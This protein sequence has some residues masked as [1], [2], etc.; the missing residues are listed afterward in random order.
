MNRLPC[1]ALLCVFVFG[2][3]AHAAEKV[4]NQQFKSAGAIRHVTLYRDRAM[5]T[6]EIVVPPGDALR[7]IGVSDLPARAFPESLSAEGDE[8]TVVRAVRVSEHQAAKPRSDA[9][10][11]AAQE[12]QHLNQQLEDARKLLDVANQNLAS[13]DELVSFSVVAGKNDLNHG[14]LNAETLTTLAD[15][16][17]TKRHELL[18]EQL[19]CQQRLNDLK[20]ELRITQRQRRALR[21]GADQGTC[22]ARIFVETEKGAAARVQLSYL[23]ADCGWSPQYTVHGRAGEPTFDVRYSA[24]IEQRSGEPWQG[25]RL[26]LSTAS[27]S[28]SAARPVLTPLRITSID[29]NKAAGDLKHAG[30]GSDPFDAA[31]DLPRRDDLSGMLQSLRARQQQAENQI[32]IMD[33]DASPK[34]RDILLNSLAGKM[35]EIELQAE[36]K[37]WRTL[38]PDANGDIASQVYTLARPVTLDSR[39]ETQLVQIVDMQLPGKMYYV[40]T[41]LLSTYAYREVS[42][43][44]SQPI[45][46]LRGPT[47]VYLNDRFVGHTQ[48]PST[49]SGQQLAIG[50]GADQQVR[51]RREL[52]NKQDN[53]QGGNRRLQFTYRLVL[54]NFKDQPV[55]VQLMDRMPMTRETQQL[56]VRLDDPKVP[57]SDDGLYQRVLRPTGVLRWDV[58]V[59]AGRNGSKAMDVE[60][61]YTV[62]FDRNR[63]PNVQQMVT[64]IQAD[65]QDLSLPAGGMGGGF[66]GGMGGR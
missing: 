16:S 11:K 63:V 55:T 15:Y 61:S 8:H 13:L 21:G 35:Q 36:A 45:G 50:F 57:L 49:A 40:A 5:V 53:V 19:Q 64:E 24:L 42:L 17:M 9:A 58:A 26:T 51:T 54:A 6:R 31:P 59:P 23:V 46:L 44:N 48:I 43:T 60:Y 39:H 7:S 29:P 4:A 18:R 65:Y 14:V 10:R 30:P 41:P 1:K 12:I 28:V 27:P 32:N 25:V 34:R 52:L 62:E 20:T 37:S 3:L 56:S 33:M 22:R 47:S 38:A 66:G 2:S